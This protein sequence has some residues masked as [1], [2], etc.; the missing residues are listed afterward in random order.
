MFT[1]DAAVTQF[2][3]E[4]RGAMERLANV[5]KMTFV[6]KLAGKV[7]RGAQHVAIRCAVDL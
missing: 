5:E 3:R 2:D 4:N 1:E 6:E 7:V